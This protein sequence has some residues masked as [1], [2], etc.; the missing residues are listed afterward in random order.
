MDLTVQLL[1]RTDATGLAETLASV[2]AARAAARLALEI[3]LVP[4]HLSA[5]GLETL[6][7]CCGQDPLLQWITGTEAG[8][9]SQA[10]ALNRAAQRARGRWIWWLEVGDRLLEPALKGWAAVVALHPDALVIA[11]EGEELDGAGQVLRRYHTFPPGADLGQRLQQHLYCPGAVSWNRHLRPLLGPLPEPLA[12]SYRELWLLQ[13]IEKLGDRLVVVPEPW[14]RTHQL[15]DWQQPGRCRCRALELTEQLAALWGQAPGELLHR[16]GL[17]LQQGEAQRPAGTTA[18]QE[19]D[20]ALGEARPWLDGDTWRRLRVSWS[21]D[22]AI[23]PWQQRAEEL[24]AQGRLEDLWCVT[25]LR[26]LLHPELGAL[27]LGSA[28]GPNLRLAERLLSSQ[29]WGD[30]RLLRQDAQLIGLLNRPVGGVPLV[31]LLHWLANPPLQ[32]RFPPSDGLTAFARWWA[33][34][35]C[36]Y[37]P[38]LRLSAVGTL[39]AEPWQEEPLA[40]AA[41]R[42]FG[43]N[44]IG[45]AFEVFGIGEDVR[46]AALALDSAGVPFCVVNVPAN[47]GAAASDRSLE[48]H[49]LPPGEL[50]PYCFNLVCLA[51]PSHGAWIAREGLAQQRGRTTIVAWPW[52]TQTWPSAWECMIPLA[53]AFWPSSTFTAKAL[54]PFSDPG[55]RPLQVMPMAVHIDH[56]EQYRQPQRRRATRRRWGLDSEARLVLF[57]FD[58]KSSLARK[59]PW[60]AIE[61]FQRAFPHTGAERVQLVIKALR[62]Q[63]ENAEWQR[64]QASA[65]GDPRLKVIETDLR[66]QDLLELM[67]CCD[68]FLSLHRSEGFGRGIAEAGILGLQV[69]ASAFGGN[70][71]FSEGE[72]FH[73]VPCTP[74][75]IP[76]GAY[77]QA[78]GH[79]WGDPDLE[80]AVRQLRHALH[81][82]TVESAE[83]L[84]HLGAFATGARYRVCLAG[85]LGPSSQ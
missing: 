38:H 42:P 21:L 55:R 18:L 29:L 28:W 52:E 33:E 36:S 63:T 81:G 35:G 54:E 73:L 80:M 10:A 57:V 1:C 19:L 27:R 75:P 78:E 70:R 37:G 68:V 79:L 62:P 45:H 16:Y 56:P 46:M 40:S 32:H 77:P 43:V 20:S 67:G 47:N 14:V 15:S 25:L 72:G 53:D 34:N 71:D 48:P 26:N 58:V 44:L 66:R 11:G 85:A 51:A 5:Q 2:R 50:G 84:R 61:V 82:K 74:W 13:A 3:Q 24:L 4:W 39:E 23:R 9:A 76:A 64:L 30:Y 17:Q 60:A 7:A 65:V 22:P 69:V 8:P 41:Q 49:T 6:T 83:R 31:A 59:N 12:A